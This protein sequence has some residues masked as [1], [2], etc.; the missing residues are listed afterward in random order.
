MISNHLSIIFQVVAIKV[1]PDSSDDG[2]GS[3]LFN[4]VLPEH[5]QRFVSEGGIG[6]ADDSEDEDE[7]RDE[8]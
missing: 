7:T 3:S 5:I 6:E 4:H 1:A 8:I 2:K